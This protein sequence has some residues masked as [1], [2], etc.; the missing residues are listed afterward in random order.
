MAGKLKLIPE[1]PRAVTP[2]LAV[3]G[4]A[5]A[6][7]FYTKAF[8]A[9]ETYRLAEPNGRIGHAEFEI[10]GSPIMLSDEYPEM[11]VRG[12]ETLGGSPVAIHVYVED[13]DAFVARAAEH[14][15]KIRR[16]V[17]DQFYG[18]RTAM[19]VDPFGHVWHVA[20]RLENLS[21][22][23]VKQRYDELMKQPS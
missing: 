21:G 1:G 11:D 16:P 18:D 5:R 15:A 12:P 22:A 9:R 20:T 8:G 6:L 3:K 2:Y 4:G 23:D 14:G 10:S 19:L 17:Q 13:V 7:E